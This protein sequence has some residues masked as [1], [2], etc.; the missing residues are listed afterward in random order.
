[1]KLSL[2]RLSGGGDADVPA[3]IRQ[4]MATS[5]YVRHFNS[6]TT[7]GRANTVMAVVG[8]WFLFG[9]TMSKLAKSRK[10]NKAA[11]DPHPASTPAPRPS[12]SSSSHKKS[13]H[14]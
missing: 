12:S 8:G 14:H 2:I 7:Q 11:S 6:F 4:K 10:A 13:A 9:Y 3:H 5:W 1:M